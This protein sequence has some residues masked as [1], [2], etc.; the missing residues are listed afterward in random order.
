M[1]NQE[2]DFLKKTASDCESY[3]ANSVNFII[4]VLLKDKER[5]L[6][7]MLRERKYPQPINQI[8]GSLL[9]SP[10]IGNC[11]RL[12]STR[13]LTYVFGSWVIMVGA[14]GP[15]IMALQNYRSRQFRRTLN[16]ANLSSGFRDKRSVKSGPH[17][18]TS[19]S[20]D[21]TFYRVL[22]Q[23]AS[24]YETNDHRVAQHQI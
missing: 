18:G 24:R 6:N 16:K 7:T 13:Y 22:T 9:R 8:M 3:N 10:Q 17:S 5:L 2:P 12:A 14:N 19:G 15:N 4:Y 23:W 21:L 11:N 1:V 20:L